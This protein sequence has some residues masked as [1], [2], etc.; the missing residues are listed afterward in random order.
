M[1]LK[2]LYFAFV[3]GTHTMFCV[4][5]L[6]GETRRHENKQK[7]GTIQRKYLK[8]KVSTSIYKKIPKGSKETIN[9]NNFLKS[10]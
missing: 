5:I 10:R 3:N 8:K 9:Y 1:F 4:S 6:T 7:N 2:S